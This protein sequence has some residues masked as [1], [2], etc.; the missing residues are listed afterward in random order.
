MQ[1]TFDTKTDIFL[2]LNYENKNVYQ[3]FF[4]CLNVLSE[5]FYLSN[6]AAKTAVV[7]LTEFGGMNLLHKEI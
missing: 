4:F 5:I 2:N 1:L 6:Y 3:K 7:V